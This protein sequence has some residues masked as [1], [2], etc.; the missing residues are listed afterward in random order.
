[1]SLGWDAELRVIILECHDGQEG[2]E[3]DDE[4]EPTLEPEHPG[5]L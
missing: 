3:V 5:Q 4:G 1:M 2:L